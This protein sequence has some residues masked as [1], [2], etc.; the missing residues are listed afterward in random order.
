MC[1]YHGCGAQCVLD[2]VHL[3]EF[4][5]L[6]ISLLFALPRANLGVLVFHM[7]LVWHERAQSRAGQ[8]WHPVMEVFHTLCRFQLVPP[9]VPVRGFAYVSCFPLKNQGCMR[10]PEVHDPPKQCLP[11]PQVLPSPPCVLMLSMCQELAPDGSALVHKFTC[12]LSFSI[13]FP[14]SASKITATHCYR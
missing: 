4:F 13:I 5:L 9:P 8:A 11:Q 6:G 10:H 7:S 12:N 3:I 2:L 14:L 1:H